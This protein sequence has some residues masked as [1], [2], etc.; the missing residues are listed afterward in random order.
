MLFL[1]AR[2]HVSGLKSF[3]PLSWEMKQSK[4][5][6][7][8]AGQP[9]AQRCWEWHGRWHCRAVQNSQACLCLYLCAWDA[10][11]MWCCEVDV[12]CSLTACLEMHLL[13]GQPWFGVWDESFGE[14]QV[15]T[16]AGKGIKYLMFFFFL[17]WSGALRYLTVTCLSGQR[18]IH[19][20][21]VRI[22]PSSL[23]F[24]ECLYC[25]FRTEYF[26]ELFRKSSNLAF[27][28]KGQRLIL[29]S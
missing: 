9:V 3:S 11:D 17:W 5:Q 8:T 7:A 26:N 2:T 20:E 19:Q 21:S 1:L 16:R 24:N 27:L 23:L 29:W 12:L 22:I 18:D 28:W 10:V 6:A 4:L 14:C 15:C 25:W 13:W